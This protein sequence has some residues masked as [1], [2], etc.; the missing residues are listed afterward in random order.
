MVKG[1][2]IKPTEACCVM[3][4]DISYTTADFNATKKTTFQQCRR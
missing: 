3:K 2:G 4:D 1:K